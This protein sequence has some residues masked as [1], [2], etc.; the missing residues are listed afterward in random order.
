MPVIVLKIDTRG[1][2]TF[3]DDR[4][5]PG[6]TFVFHGD[7]GDSTYEPDG[8]DAPSIFTGV[9][10]DA[11]LV[12]RAPPETAMWL[13]ETRP[14][15]GYEVAKPELVPDLANRYGQ[16][17]AE[18]RGHTHCFADELGLPGFMLVVVADNPAHLPP[19]DTVPG[20]DGPLRTTPVNIACGPAIV[21]ARPTRQR[22]CR[23]PRRRSGAL[24]GAR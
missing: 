13:A 4:L 7:N 21:D 18:F 23:R 6:A 17:C 3:T 22:A 20:S 24:G 9:A 10:Q 19:T 8:A 5:L 1:T 11:F 14:P 12:F 15:V 2:A 16:I